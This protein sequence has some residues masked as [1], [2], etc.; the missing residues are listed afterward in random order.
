VD[1]LA[2]TRPL[3]SNWLLET[4]PAVLPNPVRVRMPDTVESA[5]PS[6]SAI[7][8]AVKRKRRSFTIASTRSCGVRLATRRGADERSHR[9]ATPSRR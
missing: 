3:V 6:V 1:E 2:R 8:A 4:D 9:P 7:S 5:I